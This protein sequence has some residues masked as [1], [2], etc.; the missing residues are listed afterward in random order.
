MKPL[1]LLSPIVLLTLGSIAAAQPALSPNLA[2]AIPASA[3]RAPIHTL[4]DDPYRGAYGTWTAARD[5]KA[6]FHDGFAFYPALGKDQPRNLPVVWRTESVVVGGDVLVGP[7]ATTESVH[8]DWRFEYRRAGILEAYDVREDGIEQTFTVTARPAGEGDLVITGRIATDLITPPVPA[9]HGALVFK[10]ARGTPRVTY[11]AALAVDANRNKTEVL[12]SFDGE[13]IR[14]TLAGSWLAS[15]AFPVTVD[16]LFSA[17]V[18]ALPPAG[19]GTVYWMDVARDKNSVQQKASLMV[20]FAREMSGLDQD[21]W[22]FQM[23]DTFGNIKW[24]WSDV[25]SNWSSDHTRVAYVGGDEKWVTVYRREYSNPYASALFAHVQSGASATF[26]VSVTI[27]LPCLPN[28]SYSFPEIGGTD[29][30]M[31][32]LIVYQAEPNRNGTPTTNTEVWGVIL[33]LYQ[34]SMGQPFRLSTDGYRP[35]RDRGFPSVSPMGNDFQY[36]WM[37]VWQERRNSTSTHDWN[38]HAAKVDFLGK[39]TASTVLEPDPGYNYHQ[40]TPRVSGQDGRYVVSYLRTVNKGTPNDTIY[41]SEVRA[42]RFDWTAQGTKP[43]NVRASRLLDGSAS[44]PAN[45]FRLGASAF[46]TKTRSHW[47]V[48]WVKNALTTM[49]G[50][51]VYVARL[52]YSAGVVEKVTVHDTQMDG[53]APA[54]TF[55]PTLQEFPITYAVRNSTQTTS[56][57]VYGR[58]LA[59]DPAA[60]SVAYGVA[61]GGTISSTRPLAGDEFFTVKLASK[62]PNT[63]VFLIV[64]LGSLNLPLGD[65]GMPGCALY[66]DPFLGF[67]L[68]G[69]TD[70]N[71][72]AEFTLPLFDFP[73]FKWD[74][75]FQY[76][77]VAPKANAAGVLATQGL[78]AQIR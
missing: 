78:R 64:S 47:A 48:T 21:V 36:G 75:C 59:Y 70:K 67:L 37:V 10:D 14:L 33:N 43:V 46:D 18:I 45:Q 51:N 11:G 49:A 62:V 16:P 30:Y 31:S 63:P 9:R 8:G 35:D 15:A 40:T 65:L 34:V 12:T 25:T 13:R 6:S 20:V 69:D 3:M 53:D 60:Q 57:I 76:F 71:G 42:L 23:D 38:M 32:A 44:A 61:G 17:V 27:P 58:R 77:F 7:E 73:A 19:S 29:L 56:H 2:A 22:A 41:G 5:F 54:V 50:S 72:N 66:A 39:P 55:S 26:P 4:P 74:V 52:G 28:E 24:A 1:R 68:F